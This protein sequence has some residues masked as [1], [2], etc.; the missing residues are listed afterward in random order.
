MGC[1]LLAALNC[2]NVLYPD[3][4]AE[5]KNSLGDSRQQMYRGKVKTFVCKEC[6]HGLWP[7]MR[8]L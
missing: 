5:R 2:A 4:G 3:G 8:V 6:L 7:F 1:H